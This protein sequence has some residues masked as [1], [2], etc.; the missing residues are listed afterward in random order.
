MCIV[1]KNNKVIE[2]KL[3]IFSQ[4]RQAEGDLIINLITAD[5]LRLNRFI[6]FNHL[7][8]LPNLHL[9]SLVT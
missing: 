6:I 9:L 4:R 1:C 7:P 8:L 3:L 5:E 2:W